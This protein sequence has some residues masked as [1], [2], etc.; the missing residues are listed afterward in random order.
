[1]SDIVSEID[2]Q[3]NSLRRQAGKARRY[4]VLREELRE[5]LR[6]VYVAEETALSTLLEETRARLEEATNLEASLAAELT[7]REEEVR[8]STHAARALEEELSKA[9][10]T[11]A[12]AALNRDRRQ[13]EKSYQQEQAQTLDR[14]RVE[15]SAEIEQ[16]RY[17]LTN[18]DE[19]CERLREVDAELRLASEESAEKLRNAEAAYA[20]R[21]AQVR[22]AE[23]L[24]E[25]SRSE[26]LTH[27]A[28]SERLREITRQLESTLERLAL[29]AEGL[30]RE[31]ERA[32]GVHAERTAEASLLNSESRF[33]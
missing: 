17:R 18:V 2:R 5:L 4:R 30:A 16:L 13:R 1:V 23:T 29:Q 24:I 3:V 31:G 12:E 19:G 32:A 28:V 21:V 33:S 10:A 22:E 14:R 7:V 20:V 11:A 27:T 9:R 8:S 26:L 25:R 15:V 6:N